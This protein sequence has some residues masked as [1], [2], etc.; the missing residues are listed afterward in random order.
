MRRDVLGVL[1]SGTTQV[2]RR[3][4]RLQSV[5]LAMQAA[6]CVV[7]LVGAG[8]FLRSF[9][10]V[11]SIGTGY[12]T[13]NRIFLNPQF[14]EPSAHR[15]EPATALP[16][17]AERLRSVDGVEDVA[18]M[19]TPPIMGT[20]FRSMFLPGHDTLPQLAGGLPGPSMATISPGYFKTVGLPLVAGRDFTSEDRKGTQPVAIVSRRL[21]RLYWP[22]E[23]PIGKCLV[24][25]KRDGTCTQVVGVAADAHRN[26]IIE[27]PGT[28]YY[29]PIFQR[30]DSTRL[31]DAPR[32]LVAHVRDGR[33]GAVAHA[34]DAILRTLTS[35]LL[36]VSVRPFDTANDR[37]LRPWKLG[38]TL[39]TALGLL[40]VIV[41]AVGVY[42]VV[43]YGVS[44]RAHEMGIR[45]ALGARQSNIVDL[46]VGDG[47]R[48]VGI[49]VGVGI[50]ASLLLGRLIQS[51]LFGIDAHDVSVHILA[52][53][54]L[55]VVG[56][57]A[58]L[59]PAWRASRA[60]P[61]TAL[62]VD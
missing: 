61:V 35:D 56:T 34:A 39:F 43:A 44:Q 54:A 15:R 11:A 23:N 60:D 37:E 41:A 20:A 29:L 5:L 8:L 28:Q 14:D 2:S 31:F 3:G 17:L 10:N 36:M 57:V 40:A 24:M 1:R 42:S 25:D 53:V 49:G 51:L 12:A 16:I 59:V 19:N 48:V 47:L 62:R 38:A 4:G 58:C 18:F 26:A 21:A 27:A 46:I 32:Y 13:S 52:G 6:L 33:A 50:V 7:L 9:D 30:A 55:I 45:V 22:G